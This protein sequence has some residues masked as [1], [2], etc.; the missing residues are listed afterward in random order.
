MNNRLNA[1]IKNYI[2]L[3]YCTACRIGTVAYRIG[4]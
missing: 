3:A 4:L 2:A 1:D